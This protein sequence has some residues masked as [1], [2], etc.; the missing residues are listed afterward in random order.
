MS[1]AGV[2]RSSKSKQRGGATISWMM[3]LIVFYALAPLFCTC[4][5]KRRADSCPDKVVGG[6]VRGMFFKAT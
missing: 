4:T 5:P 2:Y 3:I 1:L 6:V